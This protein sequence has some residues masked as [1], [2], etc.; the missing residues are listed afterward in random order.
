MSTM[1]LYQT[2][3]HTTALAAGGVERVSHDSTGFMLSAQFHVGDVP[4][5]KELLEGR[6]LDTRNPKDVLANH[7]LS[8]QPRSRTC[9]AA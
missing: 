1:L 9:P 8:P 3:L 7:R 4:T 2:G 5:C 6:Q